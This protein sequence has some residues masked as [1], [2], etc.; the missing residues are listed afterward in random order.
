MNLMN[1]ALL[2]LLCVY[3]MYSL[4]LSPRIGVGVLPIR[5]SATLRVLFVNFSFLG[6]FGQ[7]FKD[8][9]VVLYESNSHPNTVRQVNRLCNLPAFNRSSSSSSID[10]S[11]GN[12]HDVRDSKHMT[13]DTLMPRI[14]AAAPNRVFCLTGQAGSSKGSH[15]DQSELRLVWCFWILFVIMV[16]RRRKMVLGGGEN[17]ENRWV[18]LAEIEE[19]RR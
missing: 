17:G 15:G 16:M 6:W 19:E 13:E 10:I 4:S 3:R 12:Y 9:R 11:G 1:S 5:T 18:R 2:L 14:N 7:F 8:W